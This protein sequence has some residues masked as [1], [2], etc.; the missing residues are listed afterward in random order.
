[1]TFTASGIYKRFGEKQV[2]SGIGFET[3]S[4]RAV[5]LLGRNGAGKTTTIRIIM[6]VFPA[7]AGEILVDG[8]PIDRNKLR[9]GYLPEEHGLYPKKPIN[10]QLLYLSALRGMRS[11]DAKRSIHE[12]LE[13]LGMG[14]YETK[15]L[16]TLSKGNQQK[17][18]LAA[19]LIHNPELVILDEPFSGL[20]PVNA[21]LLKDVVKE[22]IDAG[23]IVI[24]SSHQMNYVEEFCDSVAILHG[25]NI[26]VGGRISDIKRSYERDKLVVKTTG[27]QTLLNFCGVAEMGALIKSA[28]MRQEDVL[29]E[30]RDASAK[31][32]VM[33]A[34]LNSGCDIDGI[35]VYEPTLSD[36]FVEYTGDERQGGAEQ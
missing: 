29:V 34:L 7:D 13:R 12:W 17:I 33:R 3:G 26:V 14:E 32:E 18:Q 4:G 27:A 1:M 6:G 30:M 22:L 5:G 15:R 2:L 19:C 11:A 36:I 24:F 20:D 31:E 23:K 10:E 16:D 8:R 21:A 9:I 25:G 35:T 28:S